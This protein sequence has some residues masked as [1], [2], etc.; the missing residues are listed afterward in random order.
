MPEIKT[1]WNWGAFANPI[2][3]AIANKSWLLLLNLVP[4]LNIF[5]IFYGG[6]NAE[7]WALQNPDNNYRDEE[8]FRKIMDGW[9][10]A[11]LVMFVVSIIIA[12]F[13][14]IMIVG[15]LGASFS[16]P[17]PVIQPY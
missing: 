16:N 8:E 3:F 6:F 15:V 5:W 1:K 7:K 12:I 10:R 4:V 14:I 2:W 9:N 13:Y 11:G 17:G